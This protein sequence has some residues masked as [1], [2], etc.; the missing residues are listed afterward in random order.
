MHSLIHVVA[1]FPHEWPLYDDV[2]SGVSE[3]RVRILER[4]IRTRSYREVGALVV[5]S[6]IDGRWRVEKHKVPPLKLVC[7]KVVQDVEQPFKDLRSENSNLP[8]IGHS[9]DRCGNMFGRDLV[10]NHP[11]ITIPDDLRSVR[12]CKVKCHIE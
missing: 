11:D 1:D 4:E 9:Q 7:I 2:A 8:V 10:I 12:S 6:M 5:D 3:R